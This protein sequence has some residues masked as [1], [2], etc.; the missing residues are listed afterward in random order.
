VFVDE[1]VCTFRGGH[2]GPGCVSFRREKYVP[3][4]GPDGGDGGDGGSVLLVADQSERTLYPLVGQ[5]V[6]AAENGRPGTSAN[7]YGSKGADLVLQVPVGTMLYDAGRGNLLKDLIEPGVPFV[8]AAGGKGGRGNARFAT[9]TNRAPRRAE[10]GLPGEEREVRLSVRLIADVGLIG[11]PNAGKSTLMSVLSRA[12]PK[13]AEYPFTT[14]EPL[15]GIVPGRD[16]AAFV[17]ADL[18]GLI[19]GAHAGRGLGDRFLK[20]VERTRVLLHLVDCSVATPVDP[21][22]AYRVIRREL[23]QYSDELAVRPTLVVATKVEDDFA[24]AQAEL[25]AAEI[26]QPVLRI[27]AA[28]RAGLVPLLDRIAAMLRAEPAAGG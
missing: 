28:E 10:R 15:L 13:I 26:G 25:L 27:S 5:R 4:G 22:E 14:L 16:G 9:A 23:A 2:G 7:C 18:P 6:F 20:H 21:V 19:E 17:L 11:L 1:Y 8:I 12:R 24:R 3:R